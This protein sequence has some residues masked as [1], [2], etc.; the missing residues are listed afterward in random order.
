MICN[1][2]GAEVSNN[3]TFC[4]YCGQPL[5][6]QEQPVG[7]PAQPVAAPQGKPENMVAGTVGALIGAAIGVAAIV[8]VSYGGYVA[9][10]CGLILAVCTVK[11]YELLGGSMSIKGAVI[12]TVLMLVAP[13][14]ADRIGWALAIMQAYGSDTVPFGDA[15]GM[16][17]ELVEM[18]DMTGDYFKDLG[19]LYLFTLL[20]AGS[21]LGK[22]FKKK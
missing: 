19:L 15:F 11:G 6:N 16:V 18:L 14:I 17:H 9:S 13:Y 8:L 3:S 2:C 5:S 20:G 10:I 12:C 7:T 22:I 4:E 21:T 1:K